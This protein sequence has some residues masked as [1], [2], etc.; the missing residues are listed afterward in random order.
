MQMVLRWFQKMCK[1]LFSEIFRFSEWDGERREPLIQ[2][3][4]GVGTGHWARERRPP[5]GSVEFG[6]KWRG[7][8][9]AS[10][11]PTCLNPSS[12]LGETQI[13]PNNFLRRPSRGRVSFAVPLWNFFGEEGREGKRERRAGKWEGRVGQGMWLKV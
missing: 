8:Q 9:G 3:D 7:A 10:A 1:C 5:P 11:L 6:I 2:H 13:F 4:L 12:A